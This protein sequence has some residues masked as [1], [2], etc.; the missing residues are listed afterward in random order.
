MTVEITTPVIAKA[1]IPQALTA[2]NIEEGS[3]GGHAPP[4]G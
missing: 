4:A 2:A 1:E 3:S